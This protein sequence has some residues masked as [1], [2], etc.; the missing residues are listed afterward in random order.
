MARASLLSTRG[1]WRRIA[2]SSAP[3]CGNPSAQQAEAQ[4]LAVACRLLDLLPVQ[5]RQV[6]IAGDCRPVV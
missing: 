6:V 3:V 2:S 1:E 5:E 4:G